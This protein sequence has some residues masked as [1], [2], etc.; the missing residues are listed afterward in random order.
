MTWG[1]AF[2][3]LCISIAGSTIGTFITFIFLFKVFVKIYKEISNEE[4]EK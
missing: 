3:A 1:A 2:L 4:E